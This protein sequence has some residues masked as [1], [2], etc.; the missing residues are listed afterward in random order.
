QK[1]LFYGIF[2]KRAIMNNKNNLK[3]F[4]ISIIYITIM[5]IFSILYNPEIK[6]SS[7][8]FPLLV[9]TGIFLS[10]KWG[11]FTT[12]VY[13][14]L[15]FVGL[16]ILNKT[17]GLSFFTGENLFFYIASIPGSII[18]GYV[19]YSGKEGK[20]R[21]PFKVFLGMA[22]GL[23]TIYVVGTPWYINYNFAVSSGTLE[24]INLWATGLKD[25]FAIPLA[26]DLLKSIIIAV[27]FIIFKNHF[28]ELLIKT[29]F[30]KINLKN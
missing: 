17:G 20:Y 22:L 24:N 29:S 27:V 12:L 26:L 3:K 15:G 9:G 11:A 14:I 25:G 21:R 2:F 5:L 30:D 6:F 8:L 1:I 16:P 10:W 23:L 18:C 13:L 7:F 19:A 28:P 4:L